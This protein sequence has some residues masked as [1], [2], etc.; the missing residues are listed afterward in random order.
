MAFLGYGAQTQVGVVPPR[1]LFRSWVELGKFGKLGRFGSEPCRGR[2][3]SERGKAAGIT[4]SRDDLSR[5]TED[6][7]EDGEEYEAVE[8][9]KN[10]KRK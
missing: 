10:H 8:E 1:Q 9:A 2:G 4:R 5:R 7:K 3:R 6:Y